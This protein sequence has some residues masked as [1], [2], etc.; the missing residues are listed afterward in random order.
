MDKINLKQVDLR[1]HSNLKKFSTDE[2]KWIRFEDYC[3]WLSTKS[4]EKVKNAD[5]FYWIALLNACKFLKD[6]SLKAK[7][8]SKKWNGS[9]V[10]STYE[11]CKWARENKKNYPKEYDLKFGV[12]FNKII[13]ETDFAT[14]VYCLSVLQNDKCINLATEATYA[15]KMEL[16]AN[17]EVFELKE[18]WHDAFREIKFK[19]IPDA[20]DLTRV[21]HYTFDEAKALQIPYCQLVWPERCGYRQRLY[22]SKDEVIKAGFEPYDAPWEPSNVDVSFGIEIIDG[23]SLLKEETVAPVTN[24]D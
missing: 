8:I 15:L 2:E 7:D 5:Y 21:E 3:N 17:E 19:Y 1:F 16:D 11:F 10:H 24:V 13:D 18:E 22:L 23:E 6:C 4:K 20:N 14:K 12:L 9:L